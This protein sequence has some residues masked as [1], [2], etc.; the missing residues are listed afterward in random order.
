MIRKREP[1][2]LFSGLVGPGLLPLIVDYASSLSRVGAN[3]GLGEDLRADVE[4]FSES[5]GRWIVQVA[6]GK[7]KGF[8]RRFD[9]ATRIGEVGNKVAFSKSNDVIVELEIDELR[10]AWTRPVWDRLA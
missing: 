8:A 9:Y 6:N 10:K 2:N 7:E 5:N 4:L 3:I 1:H